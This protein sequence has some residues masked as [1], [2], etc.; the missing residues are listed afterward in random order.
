LL[1]HDAI[2]IVKDFCFTVC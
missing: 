1:Q 2:N